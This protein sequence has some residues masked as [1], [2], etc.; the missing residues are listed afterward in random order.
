MPTPSQAPRG[1]GVETGHGGT[2]GFGHGEGTVQ[3]TNRGTP[4]GESRSGT[5]NP[6]VP[7]SNPGGPSGTAGGRQTGLREPADIGP[8][9]GLVGRRGGTVWRRARRAS[10]GERL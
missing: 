8:V 4:G 6:L 10:K 2:Y 5:H 1:E 3:T 7:G 9:P